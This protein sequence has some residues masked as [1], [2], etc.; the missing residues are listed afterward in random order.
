MPDF[1]AQ[2]GFRPFTASDMEAA[3]RAAENAAWDFPQDTSYRAAVTALWRVARAIG[4]EDE[5]AHVYG[6]AA[7]AVRVAALRGRPAWKMTGAMDW[8]SVP[9]EESLYVTNC[10]VRYTALVAGYAALG[11]ECAP[12]HREYVARVEQALEGGWMIFGD[13]QGV[14]YV[15]GVE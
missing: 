4:R 14:L 12:E 3:H 8:T 1:I 13:V 2:A 5:V 10:R 15:Y 7:T 9:F 11:A 6:E